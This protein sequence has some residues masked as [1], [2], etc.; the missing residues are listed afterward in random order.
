MRNAANHNAAENLP[1]ISL[2]SL[3]PVLMLIGLLS[4]VL[5]FLPENN[6]L[7]DALKVVTAVCSVG[8]MPGL[9]LVAAFRPLAQM[10]ILEYLGISILLSFAVS[11][12]LT[13]ASLILH[14]PILPLSLGLTLACIVA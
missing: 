11:M 4:L 12:L 2:R 9:V 8:V 13:F 14:I 6:A 7:I 5:H 1:S 3:N 10:T